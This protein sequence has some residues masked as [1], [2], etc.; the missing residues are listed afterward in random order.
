MLK[1]SVF[2]VPPL[3]IVLVCSIPLKGPGYQNATC[4][5]GELTCKEK[6]RGRHNC[7]EDAEDGTV[8]SAFWKR[9]NTPSVVQAVNI[10]RVIMLWWFELQF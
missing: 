9:L 3:Y 2:S 10:C 5:R 1:I 6:E 4:G 8:M 7:R